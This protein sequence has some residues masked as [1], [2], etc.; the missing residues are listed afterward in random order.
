MADVVFLVHVPLLQIEE[1]RVPFWAGWLWRLPFD[2]YNQ[3]SL[4][5]FEDHRKAYEQTAP[6][7][8]QYQE[9]LDLPILQR[10]Q[11]EK[12]GAI[13]MKWPSQDWSLVPR[14]GMG[15]LSAFHDIFGDRVWTALNLAAPA[16]ALPSPRLSVTFAIAPDEECF[17]IGDLVSH[18]V[19]IQGDADQ[20]YLFLPESGT[21]LS[22]AALQRAAAL[23]ELVVQAEQQ[24]ELAAALSYLRATTI[25]SLSPSEQLTLAVAALENLLLPE[26]RSGMGATF[27]RRVAA[28]LA[29]DPG[30]LASLKRLGR[31]LYDARSASLHGATPAAADLAEATGHA[32]AQQLLSASIEQ[33]ARRLENQPSLDRVRATLDKAPQ[34]FEG[35]GGPGP[36]SDRS[37]APTAWRLGRPRTTVTMGFTPDVDMRA[38]K[39]TMLC[40]SPLVGLGVE[41]PF[42]SQQ[43]GRPLIV[44]LN[45]RELQ[46]LEEK[47]I[48]RDFVAQLS[49][50]A[51]LIAGLGAGMRLE[52]SE[53]SEELAE[54]YGSAFGSV[55]RRTARL[56]RERDLAV[57]ALR[58]AGFTA[59]H[60]PELLGSFVYVEGSR[61]RRP[62]VLRQT[63]FIQTQREPDEM[64]RPA[65][66]ARV[67]PVWQL[68]ADYNTMARHP[69]IDQALTL[70]RR[71]FDR[72]VTPV[73]AR[74]QMMLGLV[75]MML[76]R[77]RGP[78][79][80]VQLE[81]LVAGVAGVDAPAS[82]W[83]ARSGR[84]FRNAVAHGE[85][86]FE[87][88]DDEPLDHLLAIVS[89]AMPAFLRA[90]LE[91]EERAGKRPGR[92]L[93]DHLSA[94]AG[95]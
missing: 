49:L 38:P 3:L 93:I 72:Q 20:E 48:V 19:R 86:A 76:G 37:P 71:V 27:A 8:F 74:A 40:W 4:G 32:Y 75:E 1:E 52:A 10:A 34:T 59:F 87:Q 58:L 15:F 62:T 7:F 56:L 12:A 23:A 63:L 33:L 31:R 73:Q 18:I 22:A 78:R 94:G 92:V 46:S 95:G 24:H 70:Y 47:D 68:L 25:P 65:D 2:T 9:S 16:A 5:A 54:Q 83:F 91:L 85:W 17:V 89:A 51:H 69:E 29:A 80:A 57:V 39:G 53:V 55:S 82:R 88:G 67:G 60:D 41:A 21:L 30:Q 84:R 81:D 42:D 28:L 79:D 35:A 45:G 14:L 26:V 43:F 64:L 6:V 50:S 44:T 13:E 90:W 66:G 77:F 61:C 11:P 36:P